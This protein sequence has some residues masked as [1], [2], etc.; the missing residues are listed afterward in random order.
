MRCQRQAFAAL[1]LTVCGFR[2]KEAPPG[3]PF[4]LLAGVWKEYLEKKAVS[5]KFFVNLQCQTT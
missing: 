4:P 2:A 1:R 5:R 3:A